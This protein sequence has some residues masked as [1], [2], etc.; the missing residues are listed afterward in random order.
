LSSKHRLKARSTLARAALVLAGL[1]L[2]FHLTQCIPRSREPGPLRIWLDLTEQEA[3]VFNALLSQFQRITG[4]E[5]ALELKPQEKILEDFDSPELKGL[6]V[7]DLIQVDIYHLEETRARVQELSRWTP[8]TLDTRGLYSS[9][10]KPALSGNKY[11][12]LPYRIAWPA[13]IYNC[14]EIPSPP[15]TWEELIKV[16]KAH[17]GKLGLQGL[18]GE[19]LTLVLISWVWQ[20]GG[21]PFQ[22]SHPLTRETFYF[23]QK[24]APVINMSSRAYQENSLAEAQAREEI[25]VHFNGPEQVRKMFLAGVM[26]SPNC[27]A[28]LPKGPKSLH[29]A[30]TA[31]YLAIPHSSR[32]P[33]DAARCMRF[34]TTIAVQSHLVRELNWLP[35]CSSAWPMDDKLKSE[36]LKGFMDSIRQGVALPVRRNFAEISRVWIQAYQEI[37]FD[38]AP[39]EETLWKYQARMEKLLK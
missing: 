36:I 37:V 29:V 31:S 1:F 9:A 35:V 18:A 11:H 27:T 33:D 21:D 25:Y 4:I 30:V 19:N 16:A 24:L 28:V 38:R 23:L 26:P 32:H 5:T 34:L 15:R 17:P 39:V 6:D 2:A 12:F 8:K 10:L 20:A 7:P 22:L 14:R 13:M 3:P